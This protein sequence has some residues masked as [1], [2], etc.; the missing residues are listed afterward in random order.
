MHGTTCIWRSE[1][2][3]GCW[4][5][6]SNQSEVRFLFYMMHLFCNLFLPPSASK[7]SPIYTFHLTIIVQRLQALTT[8]P[9]PSPHVYM[10]GPLYTE[11]SLHAKTCRIF[12]NVILTLY[13]FQYATEFIPRKV[14]K[15]STKLFSL[16]SPI[17]LR[18]CIHTE[19][20]VLA[21]PKAY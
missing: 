4:S 14:G 5:S 13:E 20:Y 17:S 16:K 12:D 10:A 1:V 11:S 21:N 9:N 7:D 8:V 6:C 15:P 18:N 2:N 3:L 19:P